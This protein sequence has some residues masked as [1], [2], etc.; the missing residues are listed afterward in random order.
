MDQTHYFGGV[1][2]TSITPLALA[3]ICIASLLILTLPRRIFLVP[4][5]LAATTI[6]ITQALVLSGFHFTPLRIL[7]TFG[8]IR[9][10]CSTGGGIAGLWK[11]RVTP[12]DKALVLWVISTVIMNTIL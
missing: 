10:A 1:G 12:L 6:P 9:V 7:A 8:W 5:L 2:Y 3:L 4:F 11:K